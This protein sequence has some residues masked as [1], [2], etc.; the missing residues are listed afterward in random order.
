MREQI[1]QV[2]TELLIRNG[3]R[4]LRFNDIAERLDITRANIHYHFGTKLDLTDEVIAEYME[5]VLQRFEHIW[6]APTLNY[7]DKVM[8]TIAF[9]RES[10]MRFNPTGSGRNSWSLIDRMRQES[11]LLSEASRIQLQRIEKVEAFV[12]SA[13]RQGQASGEISQDVPLQDIS[14]S[15]STIIDCACA[16]TQFWGRFERLETCYLA[17]MRLVLHAYGVPKE[18]AALPSLEVVTPIRRRPS[19]PVGKRA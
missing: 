1:K 19:S 5:R 16:L 8:H 15:I 7:H 12:V 2:A 14:V 6:T 11:E 18:P 10:F 3:Y 17:H 4:G 13:I 9:N